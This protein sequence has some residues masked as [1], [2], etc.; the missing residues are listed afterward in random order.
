MA[1][2]VMRNHGH[3]ENARQDLLRRKHLIELLADGQRRD[4]DELLSGRRPDQLDRATDIETHKVLEALQ[5]V[6]RQELK[7][8]EAALLRM[9]KGTWG[10]CER[11]GHA[12]GHGRLRVIPEARLCIPCTALR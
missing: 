1:E 2:D 5:S 10:V 6:E 12:V 3:A 4:E 11:C 7:E 9:D 8:I